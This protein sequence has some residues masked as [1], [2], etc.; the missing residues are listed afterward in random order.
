MDIPPG[1]G[2]RAAAAP[3]VNCL[4]EAFEVKNLSVYIG[5]DVRKREPT[6]VER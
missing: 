4:N 5:R 3:V 6:S 1:F 2:L